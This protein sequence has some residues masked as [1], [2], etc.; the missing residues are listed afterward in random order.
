MVDGPDFYDDKDIF[1]NYLTRRNRPDNPNATLEEPV[2]RELVGDVSG[3]AVLDMGCGDGAFGQTLLETG[4]QSYTGIEASSRMAALARETLAGFPAAKVIHARIEDWD[5]PAGRFDLVVSRLALHY[6]EDV[7]PVFERVWR[8]LVDGGRFIFSVEH[9][10]MTCCNR[11]RGEDGNAQRE[12]WIV[13][14]YFVT[15]RR[16]YPWMGARVVKYHR[17]VEDYFVSLQAAGFTVTHLRE[18]RPVRAR[19][20]DAALFE[21]RQRIP[22]FLFMAAHRE[23]R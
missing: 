9:P 5:F 2:I 7:A 10:V 11:A 22:L 8:T 14:D 23:A 18:S 21:R 13:D 1:D 3:A 19:F 6:V 20:T 17:T 15:G 4:C 16:A 12:A